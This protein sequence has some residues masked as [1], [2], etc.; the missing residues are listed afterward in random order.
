M[1][2]AYYVTGTF[3]SD[4]GE[5]RYL[6]L[7]TALDGQLSGL[8]TEIKGLSAG[9]DLTPL[10]S[11]DDLEEAWEAADLHTRRMLLTVS[12]AELTAIPAKGRGDRTPASRRLEVVWKR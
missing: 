11:P 10:L 4:D 9:A 3:Q 5:A 7:K 2:T 12:L 1:D 8:R 6:T